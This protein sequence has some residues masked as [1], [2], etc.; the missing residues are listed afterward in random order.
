MGRS[1]DGSVEGFSF[2]SMVESEFPPPIAIS[3]NS[4][5]TFVVIHN[6][7]QRYAN[8]YIQLFTTS[9]VFSSIVPSYIIQGQGI[10][11]HCYD[12]Q[13]CI[14]I[15]QEAIKILTISTM[16]QHIDAYF[17]DSVVHPEIVQ[18]YKL[19]SFAEGWVFF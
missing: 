11:K 18:S 16:Y 8:N 7:L 14:T 3:M 6:C 17:C 10:T 4:E 9:Y 13:Y 5:L 1:V 15:I 2:D 12:S 19:P